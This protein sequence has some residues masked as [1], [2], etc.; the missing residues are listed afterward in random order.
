MTAQRRIA[1]P[2]TAPP[3]AEQA[4]TYV[5]P[6]AVFHV[7][8]RDAFREK[9]ERTALKRAAREARR[10]AAVAPAPDPAPSAPEQAPLEPS[11][12]EAHFAAEARS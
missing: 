12:V 6:A 11:Q 4:P 5:H 9:A 8:Q 2:E 10:K 7:A 3:A 1:T